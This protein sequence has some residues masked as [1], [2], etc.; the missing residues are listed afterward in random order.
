[1]AQIAD[2][3]HDA[4]FE[5]LEPNVQTQPFV[6]NSPHS[7]SHYSQEFLRSSRLNEKTIRQSEDLFVDDLFADMPS[8]GAPLLRAIFPR[9]YLDVNRE[10][11]ELDPKM[12]DGDLPT[13]ANIRSIRVAGGLGTIAKVVAESQEIYKNRIPISDALSRIENLYK[14]YHRMLRKLLTTTHAHFQCA[15]LIDCHSMPSGDTGVGTGNRPDFVIGDRY[16]ASCTPMLSDMISTHIADLGYHVSRNKPY[17]GGFN[18][19][20]YGRPSTGLHAI[21]VE[22][23]RGLYADEEKLEKNDHFETVKADLNTVFKE[24]FAA[25]NQNATSDNKRDKIDASAIAAE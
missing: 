21:Q 17:A 22:I 16:G 25:F 10:P 9:A 1:M 23:N 12:F 19:E 20:H 4:L 2:T 13:N 14:P 8:F 18:T 15:I 11:Y 7:G 5:G 24:V 3:Q 6:F